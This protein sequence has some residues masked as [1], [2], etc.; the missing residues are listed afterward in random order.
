[1][2]ALNDDKPGWA[3]TDHLLADLWILT[4]HAHSHNSPVDD[5]PV[6]AAMHA[7]AEQ[8][9]KMAGLTDLKSMFLHRK[10]FY[11]TGSGGDD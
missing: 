7:R 10:R 5:H 6:R 1:M 9:A 11:N 4:V 3:P 8:L 2:R